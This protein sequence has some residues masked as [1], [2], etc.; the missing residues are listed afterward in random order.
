MT[1]ICSV[2]FQPHVDLA[3]VAIFCPHCGENLKS[4]SSSL[5]RSQSAPTPLLEAIDLTDDSTRP[6]TPIYQPALNK[7]PPLFATYSAN[8]ET[9]QTA[10]QQAIERAPG[11]KSVRGRK[12]QG[13]HAGS[14]T[15]ASQ[16][17]MSKT[18]PV[19][20][21]VKITI[22]TGIYDYEPKTFQT[23]GK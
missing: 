3:A 19:P 15:H 14:K 20:D 2:S 11:V 22:I 23:L 6:S 17:R 5:T 7:P 9:V 21:T 16:S 4:F 8:N 1:T 18:V 12:H 10:R 13:I